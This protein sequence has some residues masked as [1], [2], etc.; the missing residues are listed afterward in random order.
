M[1][2]PCHDIEFHMMQDLLDRARETKSTVD[3]IAL[4]KAVVMSQGIINFM[5]DGR[6][7]FSCGDVLLST[8]MTY[9]FERFCPN[10]SL[11]MP[12]VSGSTLLHYAAQYEIESVFKEMRERV[13]V[14]TLQEFQQACTSIRPD[15]SHSVCSLL[16]ERS[17]EDL[18]HK[19]MIKILQIDP[20]RSEFA[21]VY[22]NWLHE[23][24]FCGSTSVVIYLSMRHRDDME[25]SLHCSN[26]GELFSPLD[27]VM[28]SP[29][30][31]KTERQ[32]YVDTV[33]SVFEGGMK[34]LH[35][36]L[37]DLA[38][39][40]SPM[41]RRQVT[42]IMSPLELAAICLRDNI[43]MHVK[44]FGSSCSVTPPSVKPKK[45]PPGRPNMNY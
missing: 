35:H 14:E 25:K 41:N 8:D 23:A 9:L 36:T 34:L 30:L 24:I 11:T 19:Y 16:V 10:V 6:H 4:R 1:Y 32:L 39:L 37:H 15:D 42:A 3:S 12:D 18:L 13:N 26:E 28:A 40:C 29:K 44:S 38:L 5:P 33:L 31:S 43:S 45:N 17:R 20:F 21:D 2:Y 22:Y 7:F 27:L